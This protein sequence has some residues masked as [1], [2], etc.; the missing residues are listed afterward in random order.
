MP[1]F[2]TKWLAGEEDD[3]AESLDFEYSTETGMTKELED[4]GYEL[5]NEDEFDEEG[6]RPQGGRNKC[7][8]HAAVEPAQAS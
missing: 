5:G 4:Q 6:E 3:D 7:D 8:R 1:T 2:L